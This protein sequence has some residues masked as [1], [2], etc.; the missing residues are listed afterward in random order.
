LCWTLGDAK[1]IISGW[2]KLY[3]YD[4]FFSSSVVVVVVV[5]ICLAVGPWVISSATEDSDDGDCFFLK[6]IF[7]HGGDIGRKTTSAILSVA[8]NVLSGKRRMYAMI[9]FLYFI[10]KKKAINTPPLIPVKWTKLPKAECDLD[11]F[12]RWIDHTT[13]I[14][15]T[16]VFRSFRHPKRR[17]FICKHQ[18]R[19][20]RRRTSSH[21]ERH[22]NRFLTLGPIW[23]FAWIVTA[24]LDYRY[25]RR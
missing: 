25:G 9:R 7:R 16:L 5:Y 24:A 18:S 2:L 6:E 11:F 17:Q 19:D 8:W 12:Q 15:T 20:I 3:V 23:V 10:K 14:P 22:G 21:S 4:V 13:R 1:E